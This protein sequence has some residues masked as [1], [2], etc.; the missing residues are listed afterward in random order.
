MKCVSSEEMNIIDATLYDYDL[1]DK[2]Y[3][4]ALQMVEDRACDTSLPFNP[5]NAAHTAGSIA[6]RQY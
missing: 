3:E 2:Q 4:A 5:Y 6:K 1:T